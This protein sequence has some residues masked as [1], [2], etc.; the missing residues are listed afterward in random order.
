LLGHAKAHRI[1]FLV[2]RNNLGRQA[3]DEFAVYRTPDDGRKFTELYNVQI[4]AGAGMLDSSHV[5]ISTIQRLYAVLRG[6]EVPDPD[7]DDLDIDDPTFEG[8][9]EAEPAEVAY[10]AALPPETFDLIVIDECHP[11][12]GPR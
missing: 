10:S 9:D 5:V 6:R 12:G 4:L 1:L 3:R 8:D 11:R 2:D 7:V